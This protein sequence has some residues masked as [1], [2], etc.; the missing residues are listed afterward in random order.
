MTIDQKQDRKITWIIGGL[1]ALGGITAFLIYLDRQRHAKVRGEIM[2][3][4]KEIKEL[5]LQKLKGKG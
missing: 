5:Q 3:L 2:T 1:A 4:D